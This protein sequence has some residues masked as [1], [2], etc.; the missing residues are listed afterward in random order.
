MIQKT[1]F[2]RLEK[3]SRLF[4]H[5]VLRSKPLLQIRGAGAAG[6]PVHFQRRHKPGFYRKNSAGIGHSRVPAYLK[7]KAFHAVGGMGAVIYLL[8]IGSI[9]LDADVKHHAG[10]RRCGS[11]GIVGV[12]R[13]DILQLAVVLL[14]HFVY[15]GFVFHF[16]FQFLHV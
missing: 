6:R 13:L 10:M 8:G 14:Y 1:S 2:L 11:V 3:R 5:G 4:R 9:H 15:A 12:G 16:Q 7:V